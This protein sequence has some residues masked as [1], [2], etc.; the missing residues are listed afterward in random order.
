MI[1][2]RSHFFFYTAVAGLGLFLLLVPPRLHAL[3]VRQEGYPAP[4]EPT[5]TLAQPYPQA[6][7][8]GE[9]VPSFPA[10]ATAAPVPIGGSESPVSD[11]GVTNPGLN[12]QPVNP[13]ANLGRY[14]LWG[15]FLA[16]LFIF[17][18]SVYGAVTLFIRRKE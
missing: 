16:A 11:P 1:Q 4:Q 17:A 3:P 18:T 12:I 10:E 5:P 6:P 8:N 14:Y 2:L 13:Q 9:N 7:T 15:G